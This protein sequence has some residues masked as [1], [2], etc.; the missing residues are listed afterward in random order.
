MLIFYSLLLAYHWWFP[1]YWSQ[2][3]YYVQ[4]FRFPIFV[5][6]LD[7]FQFDYFC[8][9]PAIFHWNSDMFVWFSLFIWNNSDA[10][11]LI[12]VIISRREREFTWNRAIVLWFA[13][14]T[15][16]F[17]HIPPGKFEKYR[18]LQENFFFFSSFIRFLSPLMIILMSLIMSCS[19]FAGLFKIDGFFCV[20][21]CLFLTKN[22]NFCHF[23]PGIGFQIIL[24]FFCYSFL[25]AM[26]QKTQIWKT[27]RTAS[28]CTITLIL[29]VLLSVST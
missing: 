21:N 24:F 1:L 18:S 10:N 22:S 29:L 16:F 28:T 17:S 20:Q 23:S 14:K 2:S 26:K 9:F 6:L 3:L 4:H 25:P 27:N 5:S 8:L 13:M 11:W 12:I 15:I 7:E 19:F